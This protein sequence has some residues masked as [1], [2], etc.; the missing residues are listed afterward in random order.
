[1]NQPAKQPPIWLPPIQFDLLISIIIVLFT[2]NIEKIPQEYHATLTNPLIFIVGV[3]LAAL[4]AS[5]NF[6]AISFAISFGLVNII[7]LSPI[8][9]IK[10]TPGKEGFEPSGTLDWVTT[11][12]KWFVEKVMNET[13]IAIID[14]EVSTYPID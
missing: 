5:L 9:P 11:N 8:E 12:K 6:I 7:R 10:R 3:F 2:S 4:L 13:P 14:K 1:M